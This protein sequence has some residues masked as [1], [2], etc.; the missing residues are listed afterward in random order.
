MKKDFYIAGVQFHQMKDVISELD[1]G[2][3]LDLIP[4]AENEYDPNA[5]R[6]VYGET[7]LGHVPK[8][9]SAEVASILEI[10]PT[11]LEC[12]IEV[13][14]PSAKPWEQCKVTIK[15]KEEV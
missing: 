14:N 9:H 12:I 5:V 15:Q 10:D 6:I 13:L 1:E 8:I 4:D 2:I 7:M 3:E 11:G